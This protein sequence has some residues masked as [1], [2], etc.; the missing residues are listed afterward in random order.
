MIVAY[1]K[2]DSENRKVVTIYQ[3]CATKQEAIEVANAL[4]QELAD[5]T[6]VLEVLRGHRVSDDEVKYTVLHEIPR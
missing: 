6:S 5:D 1:S 2:L 4:A 3:E